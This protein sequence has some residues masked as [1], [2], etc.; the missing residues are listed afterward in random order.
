MIDKR[1][2]ILL[3][4]DDKASN[5]FNEYVLKKMNIAESIHAVE[6]GEEALEYLRSENT[7]GEH[8]KPDLIFLD[9]NMPVMD[10]WE[11][12]DEYE[13][14]PGSIK[15][16]VLVVMLTTSVN[17]DDMDQ[18]EKNGNIADFRSKPLTVQMVEDIIK[19][20]LNNG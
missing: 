11:F 1:L 20:S 17:S 2:S 18:A 4:D 5:I 9:I 12:L 3:V 10:G 19:T 6:N 13:K 16:K 14:L 7:D 8:P 15:G